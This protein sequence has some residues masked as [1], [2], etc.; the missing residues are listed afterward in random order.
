MSVPDAYAKI[1]ELNLKLPPAPSGLQTLSL[2]RYLSDN[3]LYLSGMGPNMA[4]QPEIHGKVPVSVSEEDGYRAAQNVMLNCLAALENELGD[5]N[6]ITS[7]VKL[8]VFVAC[9]DP[10]YSRQ[11]IVANGASQLLIDLFG[12]PVGKAAR[13]AIGVCSLPGNI[14]V[15]VEMIVQFQ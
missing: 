1:E 6:R 2:V 11:H 8:L 4:G 15:E 9:D 3:L 10:A 7:F 12:E 5:L 13:S 14:P